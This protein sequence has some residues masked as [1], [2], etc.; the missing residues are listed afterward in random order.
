VTGR[1]MTTTLTMGG[2]ALVL[3]LMAWSGYHEATKPLP[4]LHPDSAS[5]T[6]S[7][8]EI[9]RQTYVTRADVTVSVFNAG[10]AKGFAG[11]T[12]DRLESKGFN[13]GS[14]GNAPKGSKVSSAKVFTTQTDDPAAQLV[15][16]TLG[17]NTPIEVTDEDMG[18]GIDVYVGPKQRLLNQH[19]PTRI[20]LAKAIETCVKVN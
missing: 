18:P 10:A 20:K 12:L 16:Q 8:A 14:L 5:P 7:K 6:C 9:S 13:P 19:A 11:V 17:K 3:C 4:A 1:R 2:L 15:A